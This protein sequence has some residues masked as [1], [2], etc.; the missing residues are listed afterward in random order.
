MTLTY[1]RSLD[2]YSACLRWD[3]SSLKHVAGLGQPP[4]DRRFL[5]IEDGGNFRGRK[6]LHVAE[7]EDRPVFLRN[8]GQNQFN[9]LPSVQAAPGVVDLRVGIPRA[10]IVGEQ[11]QFPPSATPAEM[12]EGQIHADAEQPRS[13]PA[14]W[15]ELI[16]SNV[17]AEESLLRKVFCQFNIRHKSENDPNQPP[18]VTLDQSPEG[19]TVSATSVLNEP[20]IADPSRIVLRTAREE[21]RVRHQFPVGPARLDGS[22]S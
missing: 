19:V 11:G 15:V 6:I 8:L 10:P 2:L 12:I 9:F 14:G 13:E 7:N 22:H 16:E 17:G 1:P 4:A 3:C 21:F 18:L 20:G 5:A